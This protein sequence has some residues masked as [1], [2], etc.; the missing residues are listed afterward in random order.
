[1]DFDNLLFKTVYLTVSEI[2]ERY[3]S[4]FTIFDEYQIQMQLELNEQ[5]SK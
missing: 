1:M 3:Q 4:R 2:L 5:T